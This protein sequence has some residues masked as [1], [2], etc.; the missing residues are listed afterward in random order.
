MGWYRRGRGR[1]HGCRG[2]HEAGSY[3]GEKA[4]DC[5]VFYSEECKK[6]NAELALEWLAGQREDIVQSGAVLNRAM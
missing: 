1:I 3:L 2:G 6:K 5:F 4:Y